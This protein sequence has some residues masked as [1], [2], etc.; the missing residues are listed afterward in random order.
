MMPLGWNPGG[1][2]ERCRLIRTGT[3]GPR[4][5][6]RPRSTATRGAPGAPSQDRS[7][8]LIGTSGRV[9]VL[10]GEPKGKH[11]FGSPVRAETGAPEGARLGQGRTLV[12]AH[13][14]PPFGLSTQTSRSSDVDECRR[15]HCLRPELLL[16][17]GRSGRPRG[18]RAPAP[19]VRSLTTADV[20]VPPEADAPLARA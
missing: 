15:H 1:G 17:K 7:D 11:P 19:G 2:G 3:G 4:N 20:P 13:V 14:S 9:G 18:R 5:L 10:Q 16:L 6:R 8:G 12:N